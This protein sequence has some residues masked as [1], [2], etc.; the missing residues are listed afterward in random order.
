[1]YVSMIYYSVCHC[2]LQVCMSLRFT[3]VYVRVK[4]VRVFHIDVHRC[5]SRWYTEGRYSYNIQ[6]AHEESRSLL[7][8]IITRLV[9]EGIGAG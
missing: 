2:V 5:M 4:S 3:V 1:M 7:R 9:G 8:S 6:I